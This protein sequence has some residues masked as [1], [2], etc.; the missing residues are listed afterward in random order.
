[1]K[2]GSSQMDADLIILGGGCAG[3]SL[4]ARL[5]LS[6]SKLKVIVL[7]SRIQ[8]GEDRTWCG[9]RIRA[10][11]Y[12]DCVAASWH[13]WR[14]AAAE[15]EFQ[16][17]SSI[18]PYEMIPSDRFY[19]RSC[20]W[21]RESDSVSI[22]MK[23]QVRSLSEDTSAVHIQLTNGDALTATWVVDTRPQIRTLQA[24][25]LWQNFVGYVVHGDADLSKKLG[26]IPTLMDFQ[27]SGTSAIQFMYVLPLAPRTY[28]CEWTRFSPVRGEE[29]EIEA[30]LLAWL[31]TNAQKNFT[32]GRRECGSLPMAPSSQL[33]NSGSRICTA[34]TLGGSTRASTGYAFH[35][36]QQWADLCCISLIA[37]DPPVSPGRNRLLDFMD[38]VFLRA[39]QD[40]SLSSEKI[41]SSLFRKTE[42]NALIRFLAGLPH[43][44]DLWNVAQS[45]PWIPFIRATIRSVVAGSAR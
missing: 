25:W 29:V 42:P 9:W 45:L 13:Q 34:G 21:I 8:Y 38:E 31:Q 18:Y 7:E 6:G 3:L 26:G 4:A 43:S 27:P 2:I 23:A 5:A 19:D 14:I 20:S 40:R 11:P 1:M 41:L 39:L 33:R 12:I 24:P 16:R 22:Q 30:Q 32:L 28:L 36:I 17:E 44:S 35:A 10:H 37:G 15:D